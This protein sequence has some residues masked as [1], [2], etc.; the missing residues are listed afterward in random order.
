[1]KQ[2]AYNRDQNAN[3]RSEA[4]DVGLARVVGKPEPFPYVPRGGYRDKRVFPNAPV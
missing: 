2:L 3:R 1:V 4:L